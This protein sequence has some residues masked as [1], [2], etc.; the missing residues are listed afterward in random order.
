MLDYKLPKVD[1]TGRD[2][3]KEFYQQRFAEMSYKEMVYDISVAGRRVDASY[4]PVHDDG[5]WKI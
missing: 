4:K 2:Q 3:L 5:Y 1:R